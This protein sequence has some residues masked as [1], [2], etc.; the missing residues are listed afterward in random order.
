MT[1][2]HPFTIEVLEFTEVHSLP[3]TWGSNRYREI[4]VRFEYDEIGA[5]AEV[6]LAEMAAMAAMAAQASAPGSNSQTS[7]D[8]LESS[9]RSIFCRRPSQPA[10]ESRM[11]PGSESA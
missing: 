2:K 10:S 9:R 5:I 7:V 11:Q 8:R 1:P 4:L 6:D 3:D